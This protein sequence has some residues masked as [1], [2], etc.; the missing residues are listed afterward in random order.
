MSASQAVAQPVPG[1]RALPG[2]DEVPPD[3]AAPVGGTAG[4][5]EEPPRRRRRKLAFL[6][7]L[8]AG[9]AGL[10]GLAIWYL[11]FRQPIPLPTIPGEVIMPGYVTSAYGAERPMGVAVNAGGDRIWVGETEGQRIARVLDAN[12]NQVGLMQPPVSTGTDHVP[13]YLALDPLTSDVYVSDRPTGSIYVYGADGT[14]QHTYS[15][16]VDVAGWQPLGLAFD[17]AG[18]L[19]VSDVSVNPQK[20]LVFDRTGALVRTLGEQAA[21]S[22]PNG[23]AVDSHGNVY[24][25]D[26]NNG[27][28]LVF[29][30]SG[31]LAA[32]VGRGVGDGNLGLPRGLAVDAQDRVYVAD[33]SGHAVSVYAALVAGEQ[34]LAYL[35]SFGSQGIGNGEFEFPNGLAVDGRGRIYVTDSANDRV[36]VWSY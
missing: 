26:G 21:L 6:F 31:T 11:L 25:T 9:L 10:L 24:V 15:P 22:F 1:G 32:K 14:Y 33:S 17:A 16:A 27:R 3:G 12:G 35:G 28:L 23:I 8:V 2:I 30:T 34:R 19:Y 29:D 5:A 20:V 4:T 13:V 18:N 7:L 36:Q